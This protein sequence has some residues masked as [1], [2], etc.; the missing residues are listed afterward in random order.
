LGLIDLPQEADADNTIFMEFSR[1]GQTQ[2]TIKTHEFTPRSLK[3]IVFANQ[4]HL[5]ELGQRDHNLVL[6]LPDKAPGRFG[7]NT[8]PILL[9]PLYVLRQ[10]TEYLW[11]VIAEAA[12]AFDP[13]SEQSLPLQLAGFI[14]AYQQAN[15]INQCYITSSGAAALL[16][17]GDELVQLWN[18][19]V[20]KEGNDLM[21]CRYFGMPRDSHTVVEGILANA[22][23]K[24]AIFLM[25][26]PV[27]LSRPSRL[28][29]EKIDPINP[30]HSGIK[31]GEDD[32]LLAQANYERFK[33]IMPVIKIELKGRLSY[34]H[35]IILGQL[36]Q[37][38]AAC[39]AKILGLDPGSNPEVRAV[40]EQSD[41]I[42]SR[43]H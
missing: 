1:S 29:S 6:A 18:E 30:E 42:L 26:N 5:F 13:A 23:T 15:K 27:G 9:A 20:N 41:E 16:G 33:E 10:D 19:G 25:H 22:K 8:T 31:Y 34:D 38:L 14:R 2:E 12:Q 28:V 17:S 39:Y 7:R 36:W 21:I 37:D 4:G 24:M 11:G 35:G 43:R 40:R 32:F 3:R